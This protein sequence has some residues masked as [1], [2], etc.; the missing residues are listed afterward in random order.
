MPKNG[1]TRKQRQ[2]RGRSRLR[3][4]AQGDECVIPPKIPKSVIHKYLF[5]HDAAE[6]RMIAE[7]VESQA[8]RERVQH[9]EK[10]GT[11]RVLGRVYD[12]WDV[13]TQRDRYWVITSPTNLY[14]QKYF[15]SPDYALS[16]HIGLTARAISRREP[17][18]AKED[19]VKLLP[20]WRRWEEAAEALDAADEAEE[21]QAVGMRCRECLLQFA[22]MVAKPEM[23][24]SG[25][26]APKRSDFIHWTELLANTVAP[27]SSAAELRGYLKVTAKAAWQFVNW[28]THVSDATRID[29]E[30]AI[31]A[32][33]NVL[34]AFGRAL[35]KYE[36]GIPDRCPNCGSYQMTARYAPELSHS[37]PYVV[38]C[39]KCD[40][41][42]NDQPSTKG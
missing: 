37:S 32:T 2:P 17:V 13:H 29:G 38:A 24:P 10:I 36:A 20:A 11:E 41:C 42:R 28:L 35:V 8:R 19:Q 26:E 4:F 1:A 16:F 3:R 21:F 39:Q 15:S 25:E 33:Q 14:S 23:V 9:L 40:W 5:K 7:Y 12:T 27:G 18:V 22:R 31:E 34:A 30:V 6:E